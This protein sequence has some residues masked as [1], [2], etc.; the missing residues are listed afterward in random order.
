M[1]QWKLSAR[2]DE[3]LQD[4]EAAH[5]VFRGL[6]L[7]ALGQE[8]VAPQMPL[9]RTAAGTVPLPMMTLTQA[10]PLGLTSTPSFEA[11]KQAAERGDPAAA[12]ILGRCTA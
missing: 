10:S 1:P 2:V 4:T 6:L 5:C 9:A 3:I 12:Q 11:L 7:N 8:A